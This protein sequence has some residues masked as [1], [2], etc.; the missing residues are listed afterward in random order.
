MKPGR[1]LDAL[2][3]E[4]VISNAPHE[5]VPGTN[6]IKG[7][8]FEAQFIKKID[9]KS[10]TISV[11]MEY[12][13]PPYSTSIEAA[14]EVFNKFKLNDLTRGVDGW[15][16]RFGITKDNYIMQIDATA[17]TAP[18]AI[19]LAALKAIGVEIE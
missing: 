19:C 10:G 3:A 2:V 9:K 15:T 5:K 16:C 6:F 13:Y 14:W 4:K 7:I 1:E 11:G 18:H 12:T 8:A 17:D